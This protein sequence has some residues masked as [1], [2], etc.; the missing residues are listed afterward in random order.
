MVRSLWRTTIRNGLASA[1]IRLSALDNG[2]QVTRGNYRPRPVAVVQTIA[3]G[4]DYGPLRA[5]LQYDLRD[6]YTVLVGPNNAGKSALLQLIFRELV[7]AGDFGPSRVAMILPDRLY[8]EPTTQPTGR[9]LENWNSELLGQ[10]SGQPL[11]YAQGAQGPSR[12]ELARLLMHGDLVS[13]VDAM[14]ELLV[15]FGLMPFRLGGQQEIRFEDIAVTFQGSGLRG[16]FHAIAALSNADIRAIII[17]EPELSLEPRL[18]KVLRD[19]LI[20]AANEKVIVIASHSHLFLERETV[21]SNQIVTRTDAQTAVRTLASRQDLHEVTFD[22]LG[23]STE[24]LFFPRNFIIVEGASDQAIVERILTLLGT[25]SPMIKVLA[26]RG[27]DAVRDSVESVIRAL[28]PV[29]VNDSPYAGRVIAVIDEPADHAHPNV[30]KLERDLG[31]RLFILD[32]PSIEEYIPEGVYEKAGRVRSDDLA[33][34]QSLRG[35]YE[36]LRNLKREVST[37]LA[38]VLTEADFETIPTLVDAT[39]RASDL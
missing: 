24:D 32:T 3:L 22:L 7:G 13:Q 33:R 18:Q 21:G 16:A 15:R 14:N 19:V 26:A 6:G 39:R 37:A 17:D 2:A 8:V 10:L 38:D 31:D 29:I 5:G 27:I 36:L 4:A 25:P 9:Q 28:V 30:K 34:L 11:Q 35:N 12:P 1:Q 20:D 23:S